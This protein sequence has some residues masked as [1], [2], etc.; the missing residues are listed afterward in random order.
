M[1]QY[2]YS[3]YSEAL[4]Q[5]WLMRW[6]L[7]YSAV[8]TRY[9]RAV[10]RPGLAVRCPAAGA[11]IVLPGLAAEPPSGIAV[12]SAGSKDVVHLR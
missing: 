7:G 6:A 3:Q 8:G 11:T 12:T 5:L 1:V 4:N 2:E 9:R 10:P